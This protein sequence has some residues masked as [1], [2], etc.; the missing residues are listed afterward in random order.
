[1]TYQEAIAKTKETAEEDKERK[2]AKKW[3]MRR[4][5]RRVCKKIICNYC[6]V[7]N[8]C[9]FGDAINRM[10]FSSALNCITDKDVV[11]VSKWS[12]NEPISE[13]STKQ[14]QGD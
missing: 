8:T 5:Y 9:H 13:A 4:V 10:P 12:R 1:M 11:T 7:C 3:L 14:G 6:P 2:R